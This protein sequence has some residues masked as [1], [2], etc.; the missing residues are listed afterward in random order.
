MGDCGEVG[1]LRCAEN[2]GD[3][4][5]IGNGGGVGGAPG[6]K[7]G[8]MIELMNIVESFSSAS[9]SLSGMRARGDV[10]NVF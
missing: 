1:C 7:F 4:L 3:G 8:G 2:T 9:H 10:S 6:G 5:I